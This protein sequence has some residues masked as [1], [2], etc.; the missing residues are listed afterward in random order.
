[1]QIGLSQASIVGNPAPRAVAAAAA[2]GVVRAAGCVPPAIPLASDR[3]ES[4]AYDERGLCRGLRS[5][6]DAGLPVSHGGRLS[7]TLWPHL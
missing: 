4:M 5:R 6:R 3:F 1:M 2:A 7:D